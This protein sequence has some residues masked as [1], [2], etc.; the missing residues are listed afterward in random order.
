[1]LLAA[2]V[3]LPRLVWAHGYV[4]WEG[5]KMSKTAGTAV[6]LDAAIERYGPDPLR[7]F[8]LREVGFEGDGNFTW[9][10]LDAR[11]TAD[12]ADTLGNLVSRAL[13]MVQ[14]YRGGTVPRDP[15]EFATPLEQA[16]RAALDAY[17][18]AMDAYDLQGGA[19]QLIDLAA[20][21]NRYVE[22]TAPW[23][24]AKVPARAAE[25]DTVLA[26]LTRTVARL[27]G[28]AAPFLPEKAALIWNLL[29]TATPFEQLTWDELAGP[30][31]EGRRVEKPPVLFPKPQAM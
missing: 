6:S 17:R 26:N 19:A 31:V 5:V 1:M 24:L 12:L 18:T 11:Y 10:R 30:A 4:Q 15:T 2:G 25:L 27:A 3:D 23:A 9:D 8:L 20:R 21:A 16:G 14:R 13:A 28:L 29:G 7:Y 22:E